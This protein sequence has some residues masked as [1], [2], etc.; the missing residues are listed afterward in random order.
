MV[1][2]WPENDT[3]RMNGGERQSSG[4]V[5][6][7][8]NHR[9]SHSLKCAAS[10]AF[11]PCFF[12]ETSTSISIARRV[13]Q[14]MRAIT[15]ASHLFDGMARHARSG[16][17]HYE[18]IGF[19]LEKR[20]IFPCCQSKRPIHAPHKNEVD[21]HNSNIRS[22]LLSAVCTQRLVV[23]LAHMC[24]PSPT[25]LCLPFT[26]RL[27]NPP[28]DGQCRAMATHATPSSPAEQT[29]RSNRAPRKFRLLLSDCHAGSFP[30][31]PD[32]RAISCG[33]S[34]CRKL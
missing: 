9:I 25:S 32:A 28:Q 15:K 17:R 22:P 18:Y 19:F 34:L 4:P 10:L 12:R 16:E 21:N 31:M 5:Q 26:F 14:S 20:K 27:W 3:S 1:Y 13:P 24:R 30:R 23:L 8:T 33:I 29:H 11:F 2:R 7:G 6:R